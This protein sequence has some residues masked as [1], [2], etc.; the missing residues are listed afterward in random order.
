MAI[1][2]APGLAGTPASG[3]CWSAATRAS[4]A[5]SSARLR[6]RTIR[7]RPAMTRAD[8]RRQTASTV[9]CA[10]ELVTTPD[11]NTRP[12]VRANPPPRPRLTRPAS[13]RAV[14]S[15]HPPRPPSARAVPRVATFHGSGAT[16]PG[17]NG[18]KINGRHVAERGGLG[19]R[20]EPSAGWPVGW[21]GR[22]TPGW[23]RGRRP[24][25]ATHVRVA[26]GRW[27]GWVRG[28]GGCRTSGWQRA[29]AAPALGGGRTWNQA[30]KRAADR[31]ARSQPGP[32]AGEPRRPP[33]RPA[34]ARHA[35]P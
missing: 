15:R 16:K 21:T 30:V 5:R 6:S 26:A 25:W 12:P 3:H 4:W 8:S 33:R 18:Q 29:L 17:Q 22:P 11:H 28:R 1:S 20:V 7:T 9:R 19:G 2:H 35:A 34:S 24:G 10:C 32:S 23:Q 31:L 27:A 13:A 14:P